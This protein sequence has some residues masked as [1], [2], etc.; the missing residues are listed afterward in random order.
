MTRKSFPIR[1]IARPADAKGTRLPAEWMPQ[2]G[3]MLTWPRA[4]GPWGDQQASVEAVFLQ[5]AREIALRERVL[6]VAEHAKAREHIAGQ[7]ATQGVDPAQVRF[8]VAESND[9]WARDHGPICV[10]RDRRHVLL[11]FRFNGWGRK[12][13]FEAD[14]EI[15]RRV[16]DQHVFDDGVAMEPVDMVLEGGSIEC[17]GAGTI[18]TT[19]R[20]LLSPARN[21]KLSRKAIE[22]RLTD[23]LGASRVL[24][25]EHGYLAGDDTDSHVDTLARFCDPETIACVSPPDPE[26]EHYEEITA[27]VAEL[28]ALRTV[29]GQAYRIVPLPWPRAKLNAVGERL[30]ATYANFLIINHAVLVPTYDDP[31]DDEALERLAGCFPGREM[32]A[33]PAAALI[34][35]YGSVHCVTMQ[36]P[37]GVLP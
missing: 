32:V 12:Y 36:L 23:T 33:I 4:R 31:A 8:A 1:P 15:T 35:Q 9:V 29:G 14:D 18:L 16:F 11:D 6:I 7:L 34:H 26:D 20:C 17:D 5:L 21:P 25:L 24:W 2:S 28:A 22:A 13:P 10:V 3:V 27:M 30:P 37:A 19:S